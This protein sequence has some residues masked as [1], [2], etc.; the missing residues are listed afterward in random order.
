MILK[1]LDDLPIFGIG[2]H[3]LIKILYSEDIVLTEDAEKK[4]QKEAIETMVKEIEKNYRNSI[5]RE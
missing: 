3:S 2:R 4:I 1:G 5:E